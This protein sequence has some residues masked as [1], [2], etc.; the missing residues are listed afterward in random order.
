M[1]MAKGLG[2]T[3]VKLLVASMLVGLV[4][5]W[6][7][8]TPRSLIA[9]F[10]DTVVRMFERLASF[11]GWALDYILVGAIIVVPIWFIVFLLDRVKGKRG[12]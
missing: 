6:F 4:M 7:D 8:I 3:I 9:N 11:A 2:S 5:R 1:V 10:G 12:S